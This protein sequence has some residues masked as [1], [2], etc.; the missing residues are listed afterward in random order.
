MP[1]NT[2]IG[3]VDECDTV[4]VTVNHTVGASSKL[5]GR[6]RKAVAEYLTTDEGRKVFDENGECFNW[7]DA[8]LH[9]PDEIWH[10]HGINEVTMQTADLHFDM[11][12]VLEE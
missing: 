3:L 5:E 10:R 12:E 7:L 2:T 1:N 4:I 11:H 6:M 9:V 8:Y